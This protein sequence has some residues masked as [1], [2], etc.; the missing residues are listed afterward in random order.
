[1]VSMFYDTLNLLSVPI[2]YYVTIWLAGFGFAFTP[3]IADMPQSIL[4]SREIN[5]CILTKTTKCI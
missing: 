5:V 1:M 3:F 4:H 2:Y